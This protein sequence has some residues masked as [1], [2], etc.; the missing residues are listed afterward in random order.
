[1]DLSIWKPV[2]RTQLEYERDIF[3]LLKAFMPSSENPDVLAGSLAALSMNPAF[4]EWARKIA[5]QMAMGALERN[6]RSWRA[7]ARKSMRG[8]KIYEALQD[9]LHG[10]V[11]ARISHL[12]L[13]NASLI[14][15]L[16][17]KVAQ[18]VTHVASQYQQQ[19]MR[20]EDV[21]RALLKA[22]PGIG[23]QKAKLI[24]LTETAKAETA[25]TQSRAEDLGISYFE[26][27]TSEDSR[28]RKSHRHM[29]KVLV[30]W[31]DPPSP[32]KLVGEKS[33]LGDYLP[34]G[35]PRCRCIALPLVSLNEV[36]FPKRVYAHGLIQTMTRA[37]FENLS[38][39]R[40]VAA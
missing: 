17:V 3:R 38:G 40:R 9:E 8:R 23:R 34:G 37:Q 27:R 32:E 18:Q 14:R 25:V 24:A 20:A 6:A 11:G 21:S 4:A 33:T 36:R 15:S 16:P 28:V 1:M 31:S 13:E 7:A 19:G 26:W 2:R 29:D 10:P 22:L 5:S 30:A 35:A 12:V 39:I